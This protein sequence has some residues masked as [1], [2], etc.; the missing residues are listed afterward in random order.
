MFTARIRKGN[1]CFIAAFAQDM[2]K[3]G[4]Y[5][6]D[7]N[8]KPLTPASLESWLWA[9]TAFAAPLERG[10]WE[11][12]RKEGDILPFTCEILDKSEKYER[13]DLSLLE[14]YTRKDFKDKYRDYDC[15]VARII[16]FLKINK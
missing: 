2:G 11:F 14:D 4:F 13:N 15:Q 1:D 3:N 8:M 16:A 6:C 10:E 7:A 9:T 5:W 12:K